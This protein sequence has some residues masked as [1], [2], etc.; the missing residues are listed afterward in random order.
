MP[1]TARFLARMTAVNTVE[2][3]MRLAA[4]AF[5][6]AL[7]FLIVVAAFAP[8]SMQNL[9]A[10]SLSDVTGISGKSLDEVRKAFTAQG[11]AQQSYG[12]VGAL[13]TL[14]SATAYSRALQ[15]ICERCWNLPRAGVR[16]GLWRWLLWLL[17]WLA[18]LLVQAPLRDGLGAG[19]GLGLVLSFLSAVLMWWWTQHLL[20]V[21]R[22]G[23][24]PLVPGALLTGTGVV[25][26]GYVSRLVMPRTLDRSLAEFGPLGAVFTMLSWLIAVYVVVVVALTLGQ[27]VATSRPFAVLLGSPRRGRRP[28]SAD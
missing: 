6:A 9:L 22:I 14:V 27:V 23:W 10:D 21:G 7:P 13:V 16:P 12:A 1:F 5:L 20:L 28:R 18:V 3:A 25:L 8:G 15:R 26:C 11:T 24:A 2:A 4:Q 17:V 19:S